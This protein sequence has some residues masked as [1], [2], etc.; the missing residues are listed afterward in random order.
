MSFLFYFLPLTVILYFVLRGRGSRNILLLAVSLLFY[1]WGEGVGVALLIGS[2]AVNHFI[3]H[4]IRERRQPWLWIGVSA[5]IVILIIFQYLGFLSV[6]A[7]MSAIDIA[8]PL[9]IS[10]FTFQ[11][12]SMLIDVGRGAEPSPSLIKTG[13]YISM[14]PQ[15]IAGPIGGRRLPARLMTGRRRGTNSAAV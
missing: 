5:N 15:L 8:L 12:I 10:F 9:G 11:A 13:L 4:R 1:S 3:S 2:I 14:F 7:G 6:T